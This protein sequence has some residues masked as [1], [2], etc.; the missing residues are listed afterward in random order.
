M[1]QTRTLYIIKVH[2]LITLPSVGREVLIL[3]ITY[4]AFPLLSIPII[5]CNN[6]YSDVYL[7]TGCINKLPSSFL[8]SFA[9]IH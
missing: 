4:C 9:L 7:T 6:N 3:Y 1:L 5:C 2:A 8:T